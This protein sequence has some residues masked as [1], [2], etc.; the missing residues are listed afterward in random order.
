MIF[1]NKYWEVAIEILMENG[2][3]IS[4]DI[5]DSDASILWSATKCID[6]KNEVYDRLVAGDILS[7][8]GLMRII[9]DWKLEQKVDDYFMKIIREQEGKNDQY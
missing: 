8:L 1:I 6:K 7:L 4:I 9:D 3:D 2:Y 5:L